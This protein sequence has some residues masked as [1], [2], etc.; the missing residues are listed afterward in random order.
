MSKN[1][2]AKLQKLSTQ[3]LIYAHIHTHTYSHTENIASWLLTPLAPHLYIPLGSLQSLLWFWCC[4]YVLSLWVP[5]WDDVGMIHWVFSI[6]PSSMVTM[7]I[8]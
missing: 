6:V 4:K 2:N 5:S 3:T 1:P 8:K 7:F